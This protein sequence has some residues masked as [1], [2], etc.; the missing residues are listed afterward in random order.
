MDWH[1]RWLPQ[2]RK[3]CADDSSP[4]P[5]GPRWPRASNICVFYRNKKLIKGKMSHKNEPTG[6]NK[7][8]ESTG[9]FLAHIKN[10]S[11]MG[12]SHV[13]QGFPHT[14]QSAPGP[15]PEANSESPACRNAP[16]QKGEKEE[17]STPQ[18]EKANEVLQ[19]SAT[20][21]DNCSLMAC[22]NENVKRTGINEKK[23][24]TSKRVLKE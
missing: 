11:F 14:K 15:N 6:A 24:L 4:Y 17:I 8:E 7:E 3:P 10:E 23:K 20:N 22:Y 19:F 9:S 13:A 16:V 21:K 12:H 1:H 5:T 18:E 2:P